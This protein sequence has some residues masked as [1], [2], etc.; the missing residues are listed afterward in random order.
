MKISNVNNRFI[1]WCFFLLKYPS[2]SPST[3]Q[4]RLRPPSPV[5]WILP[6]LLGP[7][8]LGILLVSSNLQLAKALSP[9]KLSKTASSKENPQPPQAKSLASINTPQAM[10][11]LANQ[12]AALE[13]Y[14]KAIALYEEVLKKYP[15]ETTLK[16][17]LSV[18][19]TNQGVQLQRKKDY[20]GAHELFEKA[21]V[22]APQQPE[23]KRALA[24]NYYF[25]GEALAAKDPKAFSNIRALYE[26]AN[27]LAPQEH[28]FKQALVYSWLREAQEQTDNH[29]LEAALETLKQ[30]QLEDPENL[31]IRDSMTNL[32]LRLGSED[33]QQAQ[34]W[35]DQ[36]LSWDP[37]PETHH[38][39]Q[40]LQKKDNGSSASGKSLEP[41]SSFSSSSSRSASASSP[42]VPRSIDGMILKME[43]ELGLSPAPET[44]L[45]Q[46]LEAIEKTLKG[47]SPGE[48]ATDIKGNSQTPGIQQRTE[49]LY[50]ALFG[51]RSSESS[52]ESSIEVSHE[53]G[54]DTYIQDIL[55]STQGNVIRW[56]KFPLR[57]YIDEPKD[58][59]GFDKA[60]MTEVEKALDAW[61]LDTQGFISTVIVKNSAAAD[62]Q[63]FWDD[64]AFSDRFNDASLAPEF[65]KHYTPPK[66]SPLLKAISVASMLT[67]GIFSIA[68]TAV[69][70]AMQYQQLQKVQVIIDESKIQLNL[71]SVKGLA[72]PEAKKTK[73]FNMALHELGHALGLKGHSP[74]SEDLM[75]ASFLNKEDA[76]SPSS[77]DIKTLQLL[78]NRPASIVLNIR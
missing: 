22:L 3:N 16:K 36:A 37:S 57:I 6:R 48:D 34:K 68:P 9:T 69:G 20:A 61:K 8:L 52:S 41:L 59:K 65:Y 74:N 12:E 26:K 24:S 2:L 60:Y 54:E 32:A 21:L 51:T 73:V 62:I 66:P 39:I 29:Q 64:L 18:I 23:I 7:L 14:P 4:G 76:L 75:N 47:S 58:L 17:N 71:G 35:F 49:S 5:L 1:P 67:P 30:A 77:R 27:D 55:K 33:P 43:K 28:A 78:Y 53:T 40:Y 31:V 15:Q 42:I 45:V 38:K 63:I 19:Y 11:Q 72:T 70:A 25:Q 44:S 13:N 10:I 50:Q 46:R 56:S